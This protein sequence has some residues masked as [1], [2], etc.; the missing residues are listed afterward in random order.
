E[1]YRAFGTIDEMIEET[2]AL[3]VE[4]AIAARGKAELVALDEARGRSATR[5]VPLSPPFERL[6]IAQ[7]FARHTS[8]SAE[9]AL[10]LALSGNAGDEER[11]FRLLVDEVEPALA[12][13]PPVILLDY[14]VTQAS[15]ARRKADDPRLAERFELFVAGVELCNGFGELVDP[16]EQRRRFEADQ[17]A[18]SELGKPVYPIDERFLDALAEGVPP[19]AGN[20]LGIDR[21]VALAAGAAEIGDVQSFPEGWL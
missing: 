20:A 2:E 16:D 6:P 7:A 8:L 12:A 3:V 18:R 14:P 13:G 19:S 4:V 17:R 15:L 21:L 5:V 11:F 9:E 1:W 10:D